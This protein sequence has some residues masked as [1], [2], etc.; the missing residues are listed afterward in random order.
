MES[1]TKTCDGHALIPFYAIVTPRV[2][3]GTGE[4]VKKEGVI[5]YCCNKH[6]Y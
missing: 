3:H 1:P 4:D 2:C 5:D 6:D